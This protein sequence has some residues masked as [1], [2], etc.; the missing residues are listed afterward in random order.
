MGNNN[1]R[2]RAVSGHPDK[3]LSDLALGNLSQDG[4]L[5]VEGLR[6]NPN[7]LR[8]SMTHLCSSIAIRRTI[9]YTTRTAG[10][11]NLIKALVTKCLEGK[12]SLSPV[13][14]HGV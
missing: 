9:A 13:A 11:Y 7:F 2:L 10:G 3:S 5:T 14:R 12:L 8:P 4:N 1:Q 6:S